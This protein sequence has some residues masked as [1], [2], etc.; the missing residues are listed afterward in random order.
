MRNLL[1]KHRQ[2]ARRGAALVM[3][4]VVLAIAGIYISEQSR[5][6]L[7]RRNQAENQGLVL[8]TQLMAEAGFQRAMERRRIDPTYI[9]ET[10]RATTQSRHGEPMLWEIEMKQ[11]IDRSEWQ[12]TTKLFMH[13]TQR[14]LSQLKFSENL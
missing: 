4:L 3:S 1:V 5:I 14:M 11:D 7:M 12:V 8:Q 2:Q 13:D 10:W 6:V 9:G